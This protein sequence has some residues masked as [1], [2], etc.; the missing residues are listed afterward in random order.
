MTRYVIGADVALRLAR[1]QAVVPAEHPLVAPALIRSQLNTILFQAVQRGELTT[2]GARRQF[3]HVLALVASYDE[4][5]DPRP[6]GDFH[7]LFTAPS[8][9]RGHPC[10]AD[11]A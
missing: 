10:C 7:R 1:A 6:A 11:D 9:S 2:R 8:S 3:D 4:P 5:P